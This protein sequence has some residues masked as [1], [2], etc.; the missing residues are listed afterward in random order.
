MGV[1]SFFSSNSKDP[2]RMIRLG[3]II[4]QT[5]NPDPSSFEIERIVGYSGSGGDYTVAEVSYP[6]ATTYEGRKI[7]VL[8]TSEDEVRDYEEFDPHFLETE[9]VVAR[10]RPDS[11]G[12]ADAN[13]Y[14][15][16]KAG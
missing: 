4:R 2:G 5:G 11:E 7:I 3:H 6:D 1:N 13:N 9:P 12:W 8:E 10:F 15:A 14:A 16:K